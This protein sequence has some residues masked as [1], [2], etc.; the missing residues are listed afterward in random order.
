[1]A[2]EMDRIDQLVFRSQDEDT[3]LD[4]FI[5]GATLA[6][7]A[8]LAQTNTY[9]QLG[10]NSETFLLGS[11]LVFASSAVFGFKRLEAKVTFMFNNAEALEIADDEL[12]HHR[13]KYIQTHSNIKIV[14]LY[15]LRNITL[16]LGLLCYIATKVWAAYQDNGWIMVN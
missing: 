8:Y 13:V 9:G 14:R 4:Y 3:K 6:I 15:K 5:L 16:L 1:M 2:N 7:C 11:L 12:R 10:A